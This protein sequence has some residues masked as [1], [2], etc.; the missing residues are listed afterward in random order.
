MRLR[1]RNEYALTPWLSLLAHRARAVNNELNILLLFLKSL[2][3]PDFPR[4]ALDIPLNCPYTL[5]M[6]TIEYAKATNRK[7]IW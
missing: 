3:N 7:S 4:I 1:A 6:N 5:L 2:I